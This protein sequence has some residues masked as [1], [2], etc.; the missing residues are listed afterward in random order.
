MFTTRNMTKLCPY[1]AE[2]VQA[3]A[4]KCK[5]CHSWIGEGKSA[6]ANSFYGANLKSARLVRSTTDRKLSGICGG[7]ARLVGV[8][9]TLIRVVYVLATVFTAIIPGVMIYAILAF[10]IPSDDDPGAMG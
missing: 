5:H 4:L 9:P 1:C 6:Q 7:L 3:E 10:V 8:D 2:E